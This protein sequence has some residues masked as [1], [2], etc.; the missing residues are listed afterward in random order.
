MRKL[1]SY[2]EIDKTRIYIKKEGKLFLHSKEVKDLLNNNKS[3][4]KMPD[5]F[6]GNKI[7]INDFYTPNYNLFK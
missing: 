7:K 5:D 3:W 1:S 2:I 4:K 6:L